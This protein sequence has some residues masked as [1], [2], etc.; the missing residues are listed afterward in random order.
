MDWHKACDDSKRSRVLL[1]RR[2]STKV[3]TPRSVLWLV[4]ARVVLGVRETCPFWDNF[5]RHD[6]QTPDDHRA[7]LYTAMV[8]TEDEIE[9]Q[10]ASALPTTSS[11]TTTCSKTGT[12]I[13]SR[14]SGGGGEGAAPAPVK[15]KEGEMDPFAVEMPKEVILKLNDDKTVAV[16]T[17]NRPGAKNAMDVQDLRRDPRR[18]ADQADARDLPHGQRRDVLRGRR[19]TSSR[20]GGGQGGGGVRH[21]RPELKGANDFAGFLKDLNDLP[22]CRPRQRLGDGRRLGLLCCCDC[23]I[24]RKTAFALSEVK[25]GVIPATISPYVVAKIGPANARRLFM[26]GE[27]AARRARRLALCRRWSTRRRRWPRRRRRF[28][29]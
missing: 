10:G 1:W 17:L 26:T 5:G 22:C 6:Q 24:A 19:S 2:S 18:P 14:E 11:T 21:R 7:A 13:R 23:V 27:T 3:F 12:R 16:I 28:A 25:L 8:Y 9:A 15:A 29:M 20:T 4:R